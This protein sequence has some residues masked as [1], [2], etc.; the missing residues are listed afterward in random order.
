M[1][2]RLA[3]VPR[4]V[5]R[6]RAVLLTGSAREDPWAVLGVRRGSDIE[7]CKQA[8]RQLALS[9]HPDVGGDATK[10]ASVVQAYQEI[11]AG[12]GVTPRARGLRGVRSVGGVLIVSIEQL[13]RDP[14]YTVRVALDRDEAASNGGS[15][16][17]R[18]DCSALAAEV[19]H[20]VHASSWDSVAD[21]R[22]TLQEVLEL[23]EMLRHG[24]LRNRAG[25]HEVLYRGQLMAEHLLLADYELN[26]GDTLHF[27]VKNM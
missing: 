10:F 4:C 25:G 11:E 8:Y 12:L 23:P 21:L 20:D 7:E 17:T 18:T 16:A 1:L 13:K 27:A 5:G 24:D 26:D 6:G 15:S 19:V 9:L 14:E 22:A 3:H 2:V